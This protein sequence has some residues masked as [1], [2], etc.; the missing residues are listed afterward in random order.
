MPTWPLNGPGPST[1]SAGCCCNCSLPW[2]GSSPKLDDPPLGVG[3][4]RQ[5]QRPCRF[6]NSRQVQR[7]AV[8]PKPFPQ[9]P[10]RVGGGNLHRLVR[11]ERDR[12]RHRGCEGDSSSFTGLV[13][14][15]GVGIKTTASKLLS[16]G[17]GRAFKD[18]AHLAAYAGNAPIS[19]ITGSSIHGE[20]PSLSRSMAVR[21]SLLHS[22]WVA[23]GLDPLS[24][25]YCQRKC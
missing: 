16:I 20:P 14:M 12:G 2:R 18:A 10:G 22:P 7:A 5:L 15:P 9:R 3:T 11:A 6:P 24:K 19:R 1:S 17:E 8:C 25:A 4:L 23:S 13:S 21:N